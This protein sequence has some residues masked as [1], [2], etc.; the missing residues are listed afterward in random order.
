MIKTTLLFLLVSLSVMSG[1]GQSTDKLVL[2]L[3]GR[4]WKM[5]GVLPGEGLK[6]QFDK[7]LPDAGYASVP[8]D[9]YTDLWRAGRIEDMNFGTNSQK[10]KWVMDY[11]WWYFL[12]FDIPKEMEGKQLRVK[13][14]GVDYGCDVYCN[15]E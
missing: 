4:K 6:K 3:S 10:A 5:E 8:G 2:D 14:E 12:N 11:E 1:F 9:V 13:F 15:G 7:Y